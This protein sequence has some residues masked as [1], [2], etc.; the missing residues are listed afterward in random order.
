MPCY[1]PPDQGV[2]VLESIDGSVARK[3]GVRS[4]DVIIS[5]AG[6]SINRGADLSYAIEWGPPVFEMILSRNGRE[7]RLAG[8]FPPGERML[9]LILVPEGHEPYYV[10]IGNGRSGPLSRW[11]QH[12]I[13]R[14]RRRN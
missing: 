1:V 10:T 3:M 2:M 5:F 6:F 14:F 8:N 11:F 4:G 7:V 12:L 13:H 9:G